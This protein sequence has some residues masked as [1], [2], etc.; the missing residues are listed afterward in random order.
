VAE[1]E[2]EAEAE[3]EREPVAESETKPE[4]ASRSALCVVKSPEEGPAAQRWVPQ[5]VQSIPA[6]HR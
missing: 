2:A 3:A 5:G 1:P 6:P 4:P